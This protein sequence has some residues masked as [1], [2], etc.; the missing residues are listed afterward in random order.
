MITDLI[1]RSF[2]VGVGALVL[3]RDKIEQFLADSVARGELNSE[4]A[5][6]LLEE[7]TTRADS[8]RQ[9]VESVVRQQVQRVLEG[10]GLPSHSEIKRLEAKIRNLEE[11][12]S[13]LSPSTTINGASDHHPGSSPASDPIVLDSSGNPIASGSEDKSDLPPHM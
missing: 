2:L 11:R 6:N 3:T 12:V 9:K 13:H 4:Q 5:K 10:A 7:L 1:R 8:E